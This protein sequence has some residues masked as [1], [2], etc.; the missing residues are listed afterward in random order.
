MI[1]IEEEFRTMRVIPVVKLEDP[2]DAEPLADALSE[3]GLP[4][5]EVTFRTEH[6]AE[7]IRR[8]LEKHP[9][10]LVG[11]GTVLTIED[12]EAARE[13]GAK[14]I[15]APGFNRKIAEY[16]IRYQIPYIPG[17]A[18]PSEIEQVLELGL[19]A[20]KFFPAGTMGGLKAIR[21]LSA[22]YTMI[23]FMPTGGV[24]LE[25]AKEYLTFD[26]I[27]AVGGSWIAPDALLREKNFEAIRT[28]AEQAVKEL[29]KKAA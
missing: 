16:C 9:D 26:R 22:P 7:G 12:A 27:Y 25:N 28:N 20:V 18:T 6:A 14:F 10:M 4:A 13:A 29:K 23:D 5:A 24:N 8:M 3:G 15:V 21:A 11:A 1:N 17:I 19:H 2:A